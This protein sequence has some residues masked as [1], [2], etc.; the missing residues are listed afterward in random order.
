LFPII[1]HVAGIANSKIEAGQLIETGVEFVCD[2]G[3]NKFSENATISAQNGRR[4]IWTQFF[5]NKL[6]LLFFLQ[7]CCASI[8]GK[9]KK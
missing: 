3:A 7:V 2:F 4:G 1:W 8:L 9:W 6:C 5:G